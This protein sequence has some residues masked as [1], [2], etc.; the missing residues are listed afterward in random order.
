MEPTAMEPQVGEKRPLDDES[1]AMV[2]A[3]VG[4]AQVGEKRPLDDVRGCS[5]RVLPPPQNIQVE[6]IN[7]AIA[8]H[9]AVIQT[10]SDISQVLGTVS[11]SLTALVSA[12]DGGY[13]AD[14]QTVQAV[15]S[16]VETLRA[17]QAASTQALHASCTT[18]QNQLPGAALPQQMQPQIFAPQQQQMQMQQ[19]VQPQQMPYG[20]TL[21]QQQQ[22]YVDI[23]PFGPGAMASPPLPFVDPRAGEKR[24]TSLCNNFGSGLRTGMVEWSQCR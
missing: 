6:S 11:T 12:L 17:I 1:S 16:Q 18:L 9:Q 23:D 19:Q 2:E 10:Q 13:P 20:A 8:Q 7:Q 21:V 15:V 4:E 22:L 5:S 3:Q 14:R 24:K